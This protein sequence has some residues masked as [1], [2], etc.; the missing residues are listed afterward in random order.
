MAGDILTRGLRLDISSLQGVTWSRAVWHETYSMTEVEVYAPAVGS[1]RLATF[2]AN[3][4]NSDSP[5][6]KAILDTVS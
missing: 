3:I 4:G 2:R 5:L 6:T 1:V